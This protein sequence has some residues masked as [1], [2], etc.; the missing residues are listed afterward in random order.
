MVEIDM[1]K[2][3]IASSSDKPLTQYNSYVN[4]K[5]QTKTIKIPI[6]VEVVE[7]NPNTGNNT[8]TQQ[9]H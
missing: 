9:E 2:V 3:T 8:N 6:T 1:S 5:Y 4:V 7:D